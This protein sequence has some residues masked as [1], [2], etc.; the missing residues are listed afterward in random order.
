MIGFR[1]EVGGDW[2][3]YLGYLERITNVTF[4]S[5]L[6]MSDPGY[7]LLNYIASNIGGGIYTVNL[8]S[9]S[10]FS[11][12]VIVF[13]RVQPRPMLALLTAIPYMIIVI[14]MGYTRQS[15]ALGLSMLALVS[16]LHKSTIKFTLWI[17][18]AACFHKSA[19]LLIPIAALLS[20]KNRWF[21][22]FWVAIAGFGAYFT[23]LADD[24]DT[25]YTNYIEAQYQSQGAL[26]RIAMC[27]LPASLFLYYRPFF[28]MNKKEKQLWTWFSILSIIALFILLL[29][30]ASTA[31]DRVALYLLPLQLVIFSHLPEVLGA[32]GKYNT[33]LVLLICLYCGVVQFVWLF[34][35]GHSFAWLPYQFYPFTLL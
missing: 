5:V 4:T 6:L 35:A 17:I 18:M 11:F 31:V 26:I 20:N 19:V 32:K 2:F 7:Q 27:V 24:V 3:S 29:T 8:I 21:T 14:A 34:F 33:Q 25:L 22:I 15:I 1:F 12:G 13:C 16:L 10:I 28:I 30:T 23:L 9:G